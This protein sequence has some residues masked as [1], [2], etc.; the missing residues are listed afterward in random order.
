MQKD[1]IL[2]ILSSSGVSS[3]D[4]KLFESKLKDKK[5]TIEDCDKLLVKLGY[6]KVFVVDDDFDN[7]DD[8]D[9]DE[10]V[11]YEKTKHKQHLEN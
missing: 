11:S 6:E 10:F 8:E 3:E 9:D 2:Y 1:S 7:Y 5:F 4:L